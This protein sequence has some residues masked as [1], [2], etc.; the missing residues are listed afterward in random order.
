MMYLSNKNFFCSINLQFPKNSATK[1]ESLTLWK[2]RHQSR[3]VDLASIRRKSSSHTSSKPLAVYTRF[4]I[5]FQPCRTRAEKEKVYSRQYSAP[6]LKRKSSRFGLG[7]LLG[8]TPPNNS[9]PGRVALLMLALDVAVYLLYYSMFLH[10][11]I[12]TYTYKQTY[13]HL[14]THLCTRETRNAMF[15]V[16]TCVVSLMVH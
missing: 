3:A 13:T 8:S 2:N 4:S 10:I 5:V 7:Q 6:I 9:I 12:Y 14:F 15:D 11:Y 1:N 16:E